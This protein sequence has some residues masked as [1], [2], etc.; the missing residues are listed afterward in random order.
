MGFAWKFL[1]PLALINLIIIG[2]EVVGFDG[3]IPWWMMFVNFFAAGVLVLI[4]SKSYNLG[5]GRVEVKV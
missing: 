4:F 5:G 1:F 2:A 3:N